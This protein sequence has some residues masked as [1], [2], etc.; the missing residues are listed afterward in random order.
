MATFE[1]LLAKIETIAVGNTDEIKA[2]VQAVKDALAANT[3]G[4]A[5]VK[6]SNDQQQ[7]LIEKIIDKL[8]ESTPVNPNP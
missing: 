8:A 2:D 1:E 6:L 5:E 7:E 4:D 3:A